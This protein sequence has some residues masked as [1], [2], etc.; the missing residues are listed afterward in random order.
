MKKPLSFSYDGER[1][2]LTVE[3]MAYSGQLFRAFAG[4]DDGVGLSLHTP[5][6]IRRRDD[7]VIEVA[8]LNCK[9]VND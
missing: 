4:T 8:L 1:D 5:F 2:V 9:V 3:G 7:G 6:I